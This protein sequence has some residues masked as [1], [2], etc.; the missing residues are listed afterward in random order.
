MHDWWSPIIA[1][2]TGFLAAVVAE[3]RHA[4][5][6]LSSIIVNLS[7]GTDTVADAAWELKVLEV[8]TK[9]ILSTGILDLTAEQIEA[10]RHLQGVS[11]QRAAEIVRT[12]PAQRARPSRWGY[13]SWTSCL[14]IPPRASDTQS[15]PS[16]RDVGSLP[17]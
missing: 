11:D 10:L 6:V 8:G 15:R 12:W 17:G 16:S 3:L 13:L 1:T 7:V 14:P 5:L 2:V 9:R 4:E